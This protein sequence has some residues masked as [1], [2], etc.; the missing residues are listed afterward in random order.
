MV[1]SAELIKIEEDFYFLHKFMAYYGWTDII[2]TH[3]SARVDSE[4]FLM[5]PFS[6][7]FE[8]VERKDLI[9]VDYNGCVQNNIQHPI[10]PAGFVIHQAIYECC[11][12]VGCI[13][14]THTD[15]GVAVS[16]LEG[17]LLLVDQ[18]SLMFHKEIGYHDFEGV[19]VD[20]S[21]KNSL[22]SDLGRKKCLILRNH[23]LLA[24]G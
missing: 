12:E 5:S 15:D 14:H 7:L 17:E 6:V 2:L 3:L 13:I 20:G 9:L 21:E 10:N 23:G 19:V 16:C 4:L 18:M 1:N 22:I 8:K 24:V 11:P